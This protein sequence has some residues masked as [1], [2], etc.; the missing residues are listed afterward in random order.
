MAAP[1]TRWSGYSITDHPPRRVEN[2][3]PRARCDSQSQSMTVNRAN[4]NANA[5][6]HSW[7]MTRDLNAASTPDPGSACSVPNTRGGGS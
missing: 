2:S 7:A 6:A 4:L 3:R 5:S 1:P